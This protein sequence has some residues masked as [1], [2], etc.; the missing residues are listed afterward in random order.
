MPS[1]YA[2]VHIWLRVQ[3]ELSAA[4]LLQP[5]T[6]GQPTLFLVFATAQQR[7]NLP[8]LVYGVYEI[9]WLTAPLHTR[10]FTE[11]WD[12]HKAHHGHWT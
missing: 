6:I 9:H 12:L 8:S 1:T 10:T 5:K 3:A 4:V 2:T 11:S 7:P